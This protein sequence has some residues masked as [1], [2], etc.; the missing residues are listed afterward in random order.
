MPFQNGL[1]RRVF[2]KSFFWNSLLVID[3][4]F[5]VINYTVIFWRVMAFQ[6]FFWSVVASN[7]LETMCFE[8]KTWSTNEIVWGLIFFLILF[9]WSWIN[10]ETMLNLGMFVELI[11]KA[12]LF[13]YSLASS[14]PCI[15]TFTTIVICYQLINSLHK[16]Y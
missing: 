1:K 10:L 7:R 9:A 3:Y 6:S 13:D 16:S 12:I 14:K 8:A 15:H 4:R 5:L 2:S 11:L